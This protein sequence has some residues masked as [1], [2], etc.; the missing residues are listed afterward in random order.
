[1][2]T[3]FV[4]LIF[5]MMLLGA[6]VTRGKDFPSEVAWIKM[7]STKQQDVSQLLGQPYQVGNA[8]GTSTWT[9]G[10]YKFR[11]I[12]DSN[13]KELKFWWNPDKTVKYYSFSSSFPM[14]KG[15]ATAKPDAA[16]PPPANYQ[17]YPIN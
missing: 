15:K 2:R 10:Y 12:G 7:N 16:T 1:M 9:Y 4:A 5:G 11:L 8:S 6:C 14:D 3:R 17:E 13:T